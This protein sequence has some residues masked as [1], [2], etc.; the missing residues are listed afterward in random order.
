[1]TTQPN[2][3]TD[4]TEIT[5]EEYF[6]LVGLL[7]LAKVHNDAL[8]KI[9]KAIVKI[10]GENNDGYSYYGH[11]SDAVMN[12]YSADELLDKLDIKVKDG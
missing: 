4:V 2:R 3:Y 12:N 11:S 6:S 1:M 10:T 7:T 5:Q 9:E 8:E